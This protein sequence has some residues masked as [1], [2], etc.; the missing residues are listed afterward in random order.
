MYLHYNNYNNQRNCRCLCE[1]FRYIKDKNKN[2]CV[3]RVRINRQSS[4][5]YNNIIATV[6]SRRTVKN[7]LRL[8]DSEDYIMY[9]HK[10]FFSFFLVAAG[11]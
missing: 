6:F 11:A 3:H 7:G 4:D 5:I 1:L 2:N 10:P 8:G 9:T